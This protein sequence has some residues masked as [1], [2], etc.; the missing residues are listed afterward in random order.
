MSGIFQ[1]WMK[2]WDITHRPSSAYF[3]H[4][5]S[6]AETAVKS[7]KRMLQDCVL[8]AGSSDNFMKAILQY[9][10]TPHQDCKRSPAHIVFGRTLR[11][12]IPCLRLRRLV[13]LPGAQG[14]DDG[15]VQGG[16]RREVGQEHQATE[17]S[18]DRNTCC[19]TEPIRPLPH[20]VGQDWG[21]VVVE[22]R[23][24]EQI[25]VTLTLTLRNRRTGS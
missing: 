20:Q 8:R 5:N 22:V 15:Q 11:N 6:R 18:A 25:L 13:H 2:D 19:H 23:P 4:S 16:G 10:N 7:S 1:K 21:G 24:H 12:Q 3:P 14:E 9:R 17:I